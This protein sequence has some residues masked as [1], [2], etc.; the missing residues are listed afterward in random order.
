MNSSKI[1]SSRWWTE[2]WG[3][4]ALE[5]CLPILP[6]FLCETDGRESVQMRAI[7]S[8]GGTVVHNTIEGVVVPL[9]FYFYFF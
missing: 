5:C 9:L 8:G 7:M 3:K 6:F 4:G 1:F 2:N